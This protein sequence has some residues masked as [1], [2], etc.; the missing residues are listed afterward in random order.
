MKKLLSL[1]LIIILSTG[2]LT[3]C[4]KD[5]GQPPVLPPE[6]SMSID[7]SN[8]DSGKKSAELISDQKGTV[9]SNWEF[10]ALVAGFWK[11]IINTTLFVPV[12][13]FKLAIDQVPVN[14]AE[15][16][17]QWSYNVSAANV[18]YKARLTGQTRSTDVLWKMFITKE[19]TGSFPEFV[20]FEGTSKLDGT[21]GQWILNESALSQV[22]MLQIDWTKTGTSIGNIK[23]SYVKNGDALKTSTIEYGLTTGSFNAYYNIHYY[24][25][26]LVRFSD[27]N[28]EWNTSTRNGRVKSSDYLTGNSW[29]CWNEQRINITCP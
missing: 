11:L 19:G 18:T 4:K 2:F 10:A 13:S 28:V 1:T 14:I 17:W 25:S 29:F 5:K 22:P 6:E 8:F 27:V 23:Y 9:N 26:T 16:T 24:N 7:F 21:G 20:W 12:V 3:N 15:K